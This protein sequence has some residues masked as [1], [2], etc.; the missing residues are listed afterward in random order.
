MGIDARVESEDGE[1]EAELGDR[2]ELTERLLPPASDSGSPC[3]RFIDPYGDTTFNQL[4]LPA[5]IAELEAAVSNATDPQVVA[6][7]R[8]SLRLARQ[9]ASEVH[10]YLKFY[11]D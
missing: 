3:L 2:H 1:T 4:Q 11:G 9:A 6:H 10:T 7:G 8:K 5:L